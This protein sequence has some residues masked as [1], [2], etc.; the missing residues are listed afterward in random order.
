MANCT[1]TQFKK[2]TAIIEGTEI[3]AIARWA[4]NGRKYVWNNPTQKQAD[5][6]IKKYHFEQICGE[7]LWLEW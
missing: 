7:C 5:A 6:L 2:R 3:K 1:R 4:K